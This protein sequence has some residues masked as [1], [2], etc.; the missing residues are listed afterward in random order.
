MS[1]PNPF[2][3]ASEHV[4]TS[5]SSDYCVLAAGRNT[6][7]RDKLRTQ[8][9]TAIKKD[10]DV[11]ARVRHEYEVDDDE[12]FED[13]IEQ[14]EIEED[15]YNNNSRYDH[16]YTFRPGADDIAEFSRLVHNKMEQC[17]QPDAST[18]EV[19][20]V[21]FTQRYAPR[22]SRWLQKVLSH[23]LQR[24]VRE[25]QCHR[26]DDIDDF[27]IAWQKPDYMEMV[28]RNCEE[29]SQG[30]KF[31]D[32]KHYQQFKQMVLRNA[33]MTDLIFTGHSK[34]K[35]NIVCACLLRLEAMTCDTYTANLQ[36]VCAFPTRAGRGSLLLQEVIK[37][38]QERPI[39]KKIDLFLYNDDDGGATRRFYENHGFKKEALPENELPPG[40]AN[41]VRMVLYLGCGR[42]P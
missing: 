6:Q 14:D 33:G 27:L 1:W 29:V 23:L 32:R 4:H 12:P 13:K 17:P 38:C 40:Y 25:K 10:R 24:S 21:I 5:I 30:Q 28:T 22:T 9:Q 34:K 8:R 19:K 26:Y 3:V 18:N 42:N 7:Q 35:N 20:N 37:F 15:E 31:Y 36:N 16:D 39:I 41:F 11:E 2:I